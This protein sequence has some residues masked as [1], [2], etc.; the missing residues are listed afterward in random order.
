[1]SAVLREQHDLPGLEQRDGAG[2]GCQRRFGSVDR[3]HVRKRHPVERPV[4]R[5]RGRVQVRVQIDV[6]NGDVSDR[7]S[8]PGDRPDPDGAFA[9]EDED[10]PITFLKR[11][12]DTSR[13][14]PHDLDD[15][16]QVL[17]PGSGSVGPPGNDL[18]AT[19]VVDLEAGAGEPLRQSGGAESGGRLFLAD[20]ACAGAR[21][22]ADQR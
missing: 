17:C 2:G 10:R 11:I 6:D 15:G 12:G 9:A 8:D 5:A 16:F 7:R 4:G 13:D 22:S 18:R 14:R 19:E 1:V 21:G 3:Q 20:A